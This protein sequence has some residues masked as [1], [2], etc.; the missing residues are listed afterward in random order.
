MNNLELMRNRLE[1]QGGI[2]QEDRMIKDKQRTLMRALKYSYQACTIQKVQPYNEV[3]PYDWASEETPQSEL[4]QYPFDRALINPDK[5]KQDYD[6]KILSIDYSA[7]YEPGDVFEWKKTGTYWLIYLQEITE[8]AYFR[9]EIRRCRYRIKFKDKDGNWVSTWAAIRGPVETQINSIQKNQQRIDE[10][11]LSLN[12]LMP[13]NEITLSAF[14]RY[15][16]FLF[17]GKAWRVEAP[18]SISMKNIIEVN[19]EEYYINQQNDDEVNEIAGGLV[20]E[21]ID[22]TPESEIIGE[23]FIKPKISERYTVE[24]SN[25]KWTVLEKVPVI[26]C[27]I[28]DKT[29]TVTWNK[30][31]SGQFTLQWTDGNKSLEKV[32]VVESLY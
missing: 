31:V 2:H 19:A 7:G 23:T 13:C 24:D 4:P 22:P 9:G 20:I 5:V 1:W 11:N 26:I 27:P 25:G 17:A 30:I 15:S 10:P 6:D 14:D 21:P 32:I 18:D 28:D 3:L 8:D 16:K 29:V 12:I